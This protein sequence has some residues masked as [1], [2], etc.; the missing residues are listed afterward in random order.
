MLQR[1]QRQPL[2]QR[3]LQQQIPFGDDNQNCNGDGKSNR[4]F[5]RCAAE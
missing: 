1:R 3:Q 2:W 5:L 4:R